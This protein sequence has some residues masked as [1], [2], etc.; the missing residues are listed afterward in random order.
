M[1]TAETTDENSFEQSEVHDENELI[2]LPK[3]SNDRISNS[4]ISF[5][6]V[7]LYQLLGFSILILPFV[8]V[9]A[10]ENLSSSF[11]ISIL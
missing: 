8:S 10:E 7:T 1:L 5:V 9:C 2:Y 4:A 6:H 3:R 11:F